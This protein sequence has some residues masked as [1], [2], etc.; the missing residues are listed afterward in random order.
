VKRN[1]LYWRWHE[2][3][4]S[5]DRFRKLAAEIDGGEWA[6]PLYTLYSEVS[7]D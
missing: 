5:F 4:I 7:S 1:R 3:K 6:I 2:R